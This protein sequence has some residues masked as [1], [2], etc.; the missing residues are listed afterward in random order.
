MQTNKINVGF[1]FTVF[2]KEKSG[3]QRAECI[4]LLH[5]EYYKE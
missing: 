4:V 3:L 5:V 2:L 1:F